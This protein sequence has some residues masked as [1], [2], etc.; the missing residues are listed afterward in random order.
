MAGVIRNWPHFASYA[1]VGLA[2]IVSFRDLP[3]FF[4]AATFSRIVT[5]MSRNPVISDLPPTGP[6]P[7]MTIVLLLAVARLASAARMDPSITASRG[8]IDK[9]VN[10]VPPGVS[11]VKY[12]GIGEIDRNV[13]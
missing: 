8:V 9:W 13:A 10:A 3:C 5:S 7:G 11:H 4:S 12:I 2:A 6:C 1:A